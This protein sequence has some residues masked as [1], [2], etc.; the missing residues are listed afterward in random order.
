MK[1]L[2]SLPGIVYGAFGAAIFLDSTGLLW[3]ALATAL[4]IGIGT[5]LL[6]L[7]AERRERE[8]AGQPT[9]FRARRYY[10]D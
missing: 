10:R 9:V 8:R 2:H 5:T 4:A 3:L 6:S 7:G 1:A